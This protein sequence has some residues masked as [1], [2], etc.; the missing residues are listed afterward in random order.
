MARPCI[1]CGDC[2][3]ACP[4][5]LDPLALHATLR[6]GAVDE[7][8]ALG[9]SACTGCAACDTVCPSALPLS[10]G[11]RAAAAAVQ[12]ERQRRASADTARE[13]H[14]QRNARL[15][16][17]AETAQGV[18]ARRAA[19]LGAAAAAALAKARA[20]TAADPS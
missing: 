20:R 9:L 19:R 17:E 5:R 3:P 1:R 12:A 4:V 7:A 13:R 2:Q 14:R 10:S 11:F 16:R 8:L 18:Q 15:A 6:R